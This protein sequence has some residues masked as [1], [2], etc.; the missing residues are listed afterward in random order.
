MVVFKLAR[1]AISDKVV[2]VP[3]EPQPT[4]NPQLDALIAQKD[5][6]LAQMRKLEGRGLPED[7]DYTEI[8]DDIFW[9][10]E[11]LEA[12]GEGQKTKGW[13]INHQKVFWVALCWFS[14]FRE[15]IEAELG[16]KQQ[17]PHEA[18]GNAYP[19]RRTLV[20]YGPPL[21]LLTL[22]QSF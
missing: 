4:G 15:F 22:S 20:A 18:L 9:T 19:P 16:T 7:L 6:A 21:R 3:E 10:S 8:F 5:A 17:G 11:T 2:L 12:L 1:I 14:D 13:P